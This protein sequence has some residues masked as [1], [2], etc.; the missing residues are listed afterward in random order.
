MSTLQII[1]FLKLL[2]DSILPFHPPPQ[3]LSVIAL[4]L[5]CDSFVLPLSGHFVE[6]F[7][8]YE[9]QVC[10]LFFKESKQTSLRI[11]TNFQNLPLNTLDERCVGSSSGG[12]FFG[13]LKLRFKIRSV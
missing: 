8:F 9:V 10:A 11:I 1:A 13:I 3:S 2:L 7:V 6:L 12:P 5:L 4:S